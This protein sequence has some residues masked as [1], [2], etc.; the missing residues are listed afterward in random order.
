MY[1]IVLNPG[2][3]I[4]ERGLGGIKAKSH[5]QVLEDVDEGLPVSHYQGTQSLVL[6]CTDL[7][8]AIGKNTL[9]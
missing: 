4:F 3:P 1:I 8:P 9:I 7:P 5:T 2:S 6:L